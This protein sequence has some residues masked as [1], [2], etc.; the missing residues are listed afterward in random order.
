MSD[1]QHLPGSQDGASTEPRPE[2]RL[3]GPSSQGL[4]DAQGSGG[5]AERG[6]NQPPARK[7]SSTGQREGSSSTTQ[8]GGTADGSP[9]SSESKADNSGG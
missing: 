5:G 8:D 9:E 3:G 1:G 2:T 7:R 4:S 6:V